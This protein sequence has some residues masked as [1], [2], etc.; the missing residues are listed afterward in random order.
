MIFQILFVGQ[1]PTIAREKYFPHGLTATMA[2]APTAAH[3]MAVTD[4]QIK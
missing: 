4:I 1:R 2:K 3:I